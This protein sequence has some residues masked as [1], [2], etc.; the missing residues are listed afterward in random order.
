M[1]SEKI[2]KTTPGTVRLVNSASTRFAALRLDIGRDGSR[3][4]RA[5]TGRVGAVAKPKH[6]EP[7]AQKGKYEPTAREKTVLGEHIARLEAAP[8]APRIKVTK[9]GKATEIGLHHPN[10]AIGYGL[11]ME[12][13]GTGDLSFAL[14]ILKQLT[15]AGSQGGEA[16]EASINFMLSVVKGI[17]PRDQLETMLARISHTIFA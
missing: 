2:W 1:S 13:I 5:A 9:G 14:G 3:A 10:D 4:S 15:N 6:R 7:E 8:P 16:D 12:A 17:R 11:L